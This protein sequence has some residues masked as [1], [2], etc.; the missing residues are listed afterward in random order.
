MIE[1]RLLQQVV[2][3]AL[4]KNFARAAEALHL[5]Q[6]ALS[7]SIAG[8]ESTLGERLF[9]RTPKGV[10]PTDYGEALL[11]RA[12]KLLDEAAELERELKL[13]RGLEVGAL[14]IGAG[15]YPT[16]MSV[17]RAAGQLMAKHPGLR[18]NVNVI[19]PR[20]LITALLQRELD[21]VIVDIAL[22]DRISGLEIEPLPRHPIV[23]YCR[24]GH[25]LLD[26]PILT[27]EKVLAYPIAGPRLPI[28]I[29]EQLTPITGAY[30][31]DPRSGDSFPAL[32]FDSVDAAKEV[33][34]CCDVIS[35]APQALIDAD[36]RRGELVLLPFRLPKLHTNYGIIRLRSRM[37]SPAGEAF[38][39]ELRAIEHSIAATMDRRG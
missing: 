32:R 11:A 35:G 28:R 19:D 29:A 10:E 24:P 7:R 4:H 36:L 1:L 21:L 8:L 34:R 5:T 39:D 26:E 20:A 23:L 31:T 17:G 2:A 30:V 15:P 18:I 14:T 12:Q 13:F 33:V 27:A 3:L 6:P 25:P 38:I 9:N 22:A 16:A 37:L